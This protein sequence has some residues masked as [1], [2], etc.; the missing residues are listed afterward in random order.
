MIIRPISIKYTA[1]FTV[2]FTF[3]HSFAQSPTGLPRSD[4]FEAIDFSNW[5]NILFY[6]GLPI[7]FFLLYKWWLKRNKNRD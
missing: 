3:E 1:F 7:A 6:I 5:A 2:I 4:R